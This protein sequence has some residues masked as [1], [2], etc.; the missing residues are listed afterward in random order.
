M[1]WSFVIIG[2][3]RLIY[4]PTSKTC[5]TYVSGTFVTL[6]PGPYTR[7]EPYRSDQPFEV[8][9]QRVETLLTERNDGLGTGHAGCQ[10]GGQG[11]TRA[12]NRPDPVIRSR[13][14]RP[15]EPVRLHAARAA[16]LEWLSDYCANTESRSSSTDA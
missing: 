9:V 4:V 5:V 10:R 16:Y 2:S 14:V 11:R 6:V 15:A 1:T 7:A 8:L 12:R 3:R 13:L